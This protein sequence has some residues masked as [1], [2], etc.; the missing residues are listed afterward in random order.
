MNVNNFDSFNQFCGPAVL[1]IFTGNTADECADEIMAIDGSFKVKGVIPDTLMKAGV[2]MGL[3]FDE[4]PSFQGRSLF[5]AGSVLIKM[6][7]TQYLVTIPKHYIALET[8][9]NSLYI[10]DNHTK[11]EI[12]LQNSARLS[13]K[14][15]RV[16]KVTRLFKY[17][18]PFVVKSEFGCQMNGSLVSIRQI[19]T[20][21]DESVKI[22][23][24]GHITITDKHLL[25]EIAFSLMEL[26]ND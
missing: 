18:K 10:C 3:Q 8:R 25:Q 6:P 14:I 20:Y 23:P 21:S 13:Q 17:Q 22:N 12:E 9:E 15:E 16:W 4:I 19:M 2:K 1:S 11:T 26:S 5:W 7:P 24:C